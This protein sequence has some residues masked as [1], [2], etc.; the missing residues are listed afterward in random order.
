MSQDITP[1]PGT[2]F[3]PN[4][5]ETIAK[6]RMRNSLVADLKRIIELMKKKENFQE[7]DCCDSREAGLDHWCETSEGKELERLMKQ[8]FPETKR[9]PLQDSGSPCHYQAG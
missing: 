2:E 3:C 7:P 1:R 6:I 4:C 9:D 5:S 8:H